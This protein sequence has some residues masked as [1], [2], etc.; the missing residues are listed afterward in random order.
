V[1][2]GRWLSGK[3]AES[4][5]AKLAL[6]NSVGVSASIKRLA[7]FEDTKAN[8]LKRKVSEVCMYVC[9]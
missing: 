8:P 9:V 7:V 2:S 4:F 3:R 1:T 5:R 6:Q